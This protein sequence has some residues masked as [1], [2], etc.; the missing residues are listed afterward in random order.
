L[1]Q[2]ESLDDRTLDIAV[3]KVGLLSQAARTSRVSAV[4]R[5]TG[6]GPSAVRSVSGDGQ[7][8]ARHTSDQ[9][10]I[11]VDYGRATLDGVGLGFA[12]AT[13]EG[14]AAAPGVVFTGPFLSPS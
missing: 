4:R 5:A 8:A 7:P 1:R 6:S 12:G 3:G 2:I 9:S 10:R 14:T 11:L 13:A